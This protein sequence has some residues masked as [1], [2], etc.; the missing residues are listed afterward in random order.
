MNKF[1]FL[2]MMD[3]TKSS[4]PNLVLNN[5]TVYENT[6]TSPDSPSLNSASLAS[7]AVVSQI[8]NE[9]VAK[10]Q[11]GTHLDSPA[12]HVVSEKVQN[13]AAQIYTELQ[14]VIINNNDDDDIVSGK[15]C[16]I[17]ADQNI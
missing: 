16:C 12:N 14:K 1:F 8:I 3:E 9:D 13:L 5:E 2:R 6:L 10:L 17:Y 11:H 4:I 15:V 7:A